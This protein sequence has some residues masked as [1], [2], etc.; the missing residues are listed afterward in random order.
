MDVGL[1]QINEGV[2]QQISMIKFM[3]TRQAVKTSYRHRKI[4]PQP[5]RGVVK[6][7]S[8][9]ELAVDEMRTVRFE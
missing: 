2:F 8:V 1:A 9:K 7:V 4:F 3:A 6:G 5:V